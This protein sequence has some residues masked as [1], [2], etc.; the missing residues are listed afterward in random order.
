MAERRMPTTEEFP[1]NAN[2]RIE[3]ATDVIEPIKMKG[4]TRT[5]R[6]SAWNSVKHEFMSEDG[7]DVGSYILYDIILPAL[8]DLISDIGHG[9]ID[10]AM[11]T[12]SR[13]YSR[14][15]SRDRRS[16]VSYDRYYDDRDR[17]RR[18]RDDDR[19][20]TR[21]R[22]RDLD[23]IIFE[24]RE[25]A[26]DALDRMIDYLERYDDVPVSYLYDICGM[27]VPGDFTKDDWGWTSLSGARVRKTRGGWYLDLPRVRP[28]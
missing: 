27:T 6:P 24:Y 25:D 20:E 18:D 17:R 21:R 13:R 5:K 10:A 12:D 28:L 15:G 3:K 19:Y 8:R 2:G 26:D 23:D 22:N 11:G 9:A 16:Y 1:S 4:K 7:P 14:G